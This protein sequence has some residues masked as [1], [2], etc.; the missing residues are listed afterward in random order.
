[1]AESGTTSLRQWRGERKLQQ[2]ARLKQRQTE[3]WVHSLSSWVT[4]SLSL[5]P[6]KS[7]K[8]A[9]ASEG[10]TARFSIWNIFSVGT[11]SCVSPGYN[12]WL[13]CLLARLFFCKT[14][15]HF[16]T[17]RWHLTIWLIPLSVGW[18]GD[19]HN[20]SAESFSFP[21]AL[22]TYPLEHQLLA[23]DT[24]SSMQTPEPRQH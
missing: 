18:L 17:K 7:I 2:A 12:G 6:Y 22:P 16:S 21:K 4:P 20:T 11:S 9:T 19:P 13:W 15:G 1:M 5:H 3:T 24:T 10:Q 14:T 8:M 23:K